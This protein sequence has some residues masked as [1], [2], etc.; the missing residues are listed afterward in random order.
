MKRQ[1]ALQT[2]PKRDKKA[3]TCQCQPGGDITTVFK[4]DDEEADEETPLSINAGGRH[5]V[6]S[7]ATLTY[8]QSEFCDIRL[9]CKDADGRIFI[10][11]DPDIFAALLS[12]MRTPA[13]I[14]STPPGID[15]EI[16]ESV[17]DKWR[18]YPHSV[19][20]GRRSTYLEKRA[21]WIEE[22][23]KDDRRA[24]D[25][26]I[27]LLPPE[28]LTY[29]TRD[30]DDECD[31]A[32]S[33]IIVEGFHSFLSDD[34]TTWDLADYLDCEWRGPK[35]L[36]ML[37]QDFP[38]HRFTI[39]CGKMQGLDSARKDKVFEMH[40]NDREK[41]TDDTG[42]AFVSLYPIV[43]RRNSFLQVE[44]DADDKDGLAFI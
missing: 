18:L 31:T 22:R 40:P 24:V 7:M 43:R 30:I 19:N 12:V 9:H 17:L 42:V 39:T 14:H 4:Y 13:L 6:T 23:E 15:K 38:Y 11:I 8:F 27:E 26:I 36:R 41:V 44:E 35:V 28:Q 5:F 16:W 2:Q 3:K 37:N 32:D 25:K 34:G 29:F 21:E 33:K 1:T 10:D 20:R